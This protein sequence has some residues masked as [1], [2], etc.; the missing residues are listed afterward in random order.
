[1]KKKVII[2]LSGGVD[3]SVAAFLL[4]KAGYEVEGVFMRNWDSSLN[5]D[6]EGNPF[7]NNNICPQEQDFNDA[8][9][10]AEQLNIKCHKVDFS[11]DYW[12]Q[13]FTSFLNGLKANLTPNPDVLCNNKIKF[14]IFVKYVEQFNPDYIAMGHYARIIYK[15]KE[16]IL[17]KALDRDKDQTYFLS[18]LKIEQLKKVLF[19]LGELTKSQV[20]EIAAK[21]NLITAK[22]KDSTGICFIGERNFFVFLNNY[23]KTNKGPIKDMNGVFLKEHEGVIKY[24]I[25]QRKRLNLKV[26]KENQSPWFVVGKDLKNN[27]LYV[28]QNAESPYLYSD[29]ALIIDVVWRNCDGNIYKKNARMKIEAKFRYRQPNQEV[30]II[31]LNEST[32][33]IYYPQKIKLVTP[34]QVCSFYKGD[35]C[36]GAGII[37]EVYSQ[38]KKMLYV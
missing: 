16:I 20:R 38:N 8:L 37:K 4:K 1:M 3:S 11:E 35:F 28:D 19:P 12:N 14:D 9:K 7:V 32:I 34:G 2:G 17:A 33:K 23:L 22:K 30:E 10:V 13:V 15:N 24:T 29:S 27:I 31:F 5:Y 18:Q 25:G 36:L 26:T 6:V 21:E